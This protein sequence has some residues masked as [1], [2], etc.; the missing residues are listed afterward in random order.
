MFRVGNVVILIIPGEMTTMAGRRIRYVRR[1][2]LHP[3]MEFVDGFSHRVNSRNG[4]LAHTLFHLYRNAVRARLTAEGIIEKDAYVVIA[5]PANTYAHYITTREEYG[6]QRYEGASTLFGPSKPFIH[7]WRPPRRPLLITRCATDTLDAYI[8]K[9]SSL[10]SYLADNAPPG[11]V[12]PSDPAPPD[13]TSVAISLR[14]RR[15]F[16]FPAIV[17][18][19]PVAVAQTGVVFDSPG[20]GHNFGDVLIDVH[21]SY[22]VGQTV[23]AQF[24]GA[25]PRV[26][27]ISSCYIDPLAVC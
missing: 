2:V 20:A 11:Q 8:D 16:P 24:V 25:N 15:P 3:T 21:S 17:P 12:P 26:R 18:L 6:V 22:T 10:V 9:Y 27:D 19:T 5:G 23:W 14:V 1:P 4:C 13:L 7:L